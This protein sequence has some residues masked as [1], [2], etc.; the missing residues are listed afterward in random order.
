MID[1][2]K[3]EDIRTR[4]L[5]LLESLDAEDALGAEGQKTMVLDQQSTGRV[6]RMDALQHQAM[7]RA[8]QTRR[9]GLR[10]RID[11]AMSRL[12]E[13]EY[14]YCTECGEEIPLKRLE[15]DPS[16][17]TCVSCAAG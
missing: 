6:S 4:L 16:V 11:A 17:P 10:Q 14:G 13:G 8:T 3:P 12:D 5:A 15:L 1:R 2:I 9:D 7:A